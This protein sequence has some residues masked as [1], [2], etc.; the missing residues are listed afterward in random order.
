MCIVSRALRRVLDTRRPVS[1]SL[2]CHIPRANQLQRTKTTVKCAGDLPLRHET[3]T[4]FAKFLRERGET[5]SFDFGT[6]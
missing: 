1:D 3:C 4:S 2:V 5:I 6:G